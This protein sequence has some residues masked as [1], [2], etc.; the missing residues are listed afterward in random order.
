[1]NTVSIAEFYEA[2]EKGLQ[3]IE[4]PLSFAEAVHETYKSPFFTLVSI[5]LSARTKDSLTN[6][7]M[8]GL[9]QEASTPEKMMAIPIDRLAQL[10]RP[11]NFYTTKAKHLKELSSILIEKYQGNVPSE[12]EQL[13]E[14]PGVGRKTANLVQSV[15]FDIP[16]ICV[17]THVHRIMNHIGY[18]TTKTPEQTEFALRKKL[19]K[20][21]WIKTNRI[22]VL[23]GQHLSNHIQ[24]KDPNNILNK[25]KVTD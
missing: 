25:Y 21:L 3:S 16:A 12:M 5:V 15:V 7:R 17:D 14:L 10:L 4:A 1:M 11:I 19:P 9:W 8:P 6:T 24:M 13:L 2:L 23:V 22:L 20:E 18:V